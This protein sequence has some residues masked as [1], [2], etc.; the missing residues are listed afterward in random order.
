MLAAVVLAASIQV[1]PMGH[2][3]SIDARTPP[4]RVAATEPGVSVK[5]PAAPAA[6]APRQGGDDVR[7]PVSAQVS[8]GGRSEEEGGRTY[9]GPSIQVQGQVTEGEEGESEA[10]VVPVGVRC[11]PPE[12]R[13]LTTGAVCGVLDAVPE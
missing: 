13:N 1:A 9:E 2:P 8:M 6:P 12:E 4:S 3:A 7:T 11:P 5:A 10:E